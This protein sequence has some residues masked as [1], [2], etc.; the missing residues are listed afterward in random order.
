M[1]EV[2]TIGSYGQTTLSA[3]QRNKVL[4]NTYALLAVS[5][6]PTIAGAWL[7]MAMGLDQTLFKSPMLSLV[8]FLGGAFGFM[9][10]IEKNKNSGAGVALLLAFTFFMGVMLSRLLG[11]VLGME[12]GATLVMTAL[13]GT[14]VI[15]AS[16]AAIGAATKRDLSGMG[17]FLMVGALVV[18]VGA[19]IGIVFQLPALMLALIVMSLAIS[20]LFMVWDV[21]RIVNG[22]ETNYVSATMALYMNIYNVFANLLALLGIGNQE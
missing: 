6:V 2:Q 5:L 11:W 7:A 15:C 8:L 17:K 20:A 3:E 9:Y 10:L 1:A 21:N 13:G 16:M 22:G 18:L 14:A 19:V 4:R 12:G